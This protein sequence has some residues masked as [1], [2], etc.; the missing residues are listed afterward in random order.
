MTDDMNNQIPKEVED[1][2]KLKR[3]FK[4]MSKSVTQALMTGTYKGTARMMV[5]S[6]QKMQAKAAEAVPDDF[7]ITS[8]ELDITD[9]MTEEEQLTQVQIASQQ[10]TSY[11]DG[12]LRENHT[13]VYTAEFDDLRS[14]GTEIRDQV[15]RMTKGTLKNALSGIDIDIQTAPKPPDA[16]EPPKPPH[17][18]KVVVKKD[19][20]EDVDD[21]IQS[22]IDDE[23][24]NP[25]RDA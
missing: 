21:I 8:L 11:L 25:P 4:A 15:I 2:I 22:V 23:D 20:G 19:D 9:D 17:K 14:L 6:Y 18:V 1:M 16:P 5:K 13:H 10:I 3:A 12:I 24:N 7:F